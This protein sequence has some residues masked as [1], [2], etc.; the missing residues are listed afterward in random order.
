MTVKCCRDCA[1]LATIN[2]TKLIQIKKCKLINIQFNVLEVLNPDTFYCSAFTRR[3]SAN[4]NTQDSQNTQNTQPE[5]E[6]QLPPIQR[7]FV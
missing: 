5:E 6:Q 1:H 3:N 2:V 4:K 7:R